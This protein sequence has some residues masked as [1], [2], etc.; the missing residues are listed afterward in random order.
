M[1]LN[2]SVQYDDLT[3]TLHVIQKHDAQPVLDSVRLL[4]QAET[5]KLSE[6]RH[7]GRV[8]FHIIEQWVKEAGVSFDNYEAVREVIDRKLQ[9][10]EFNKLRI[11]EGRY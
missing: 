7:V 9:S 4:K 2:E 8:P 3:D 11:W 10:G 5:P 1:K 6:N